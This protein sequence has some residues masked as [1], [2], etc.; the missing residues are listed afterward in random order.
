MADKQKTIKKSVT[1][2]GVGLH[3]GQNVE[4]TY[5]PAP[6][7]HG[8]KFKRVDIEESP[9]IEAD[10]DNVIDTSRGTTLE[11]NNIRISTVEHALAAVAGLSIDNIIIELNGS[12]I[13]ILDGSAKIFID[14][15]IEAGIE[16]QSSDREYFELKSNVSYVEED[17]GV[18]ILAIP[19][20]NFAVT[21]ML[22]YNSP[23]LGNQHAS[24]NNIEEFAEEI[25]SCRTFCFLHELEEL[26]SKN[27]IKGGDLSNAIVVVDRLIKDEELED[28]ANLFNNPDVTI[29][30]EGIVNDIQLRYQNEPARHKLL[31]VV[32]DLALIGKPIK[33]QIFATR[34]GHKANI[35]FAKKIKSIMSKETKEDIPQFDLSSKPVYDINQIMKILPHRAPFLFID[36]VMELSDNHVV[37]VKNLT[38][39]ETFF[40]GHFPGNPIFPGVLQIE[41]MAQTGGIFVLNTVPD[42]ENYLTYFMKIDKAKFKNLVYPGDVVIYRLELMSPIRR[43]ICHMK[44]TTYVGGKVTCEAEMMAVIVKVKGD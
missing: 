28:L 31:D 12:E 26:V 39:N 36:R 10:V 21:V 14:H 23:V 41:G 32:G 6:E 4:M 19:N 42:P 29:N 40:R 16:E 35:E 1:I 44:G 17:R 8:I 34:P 30:K 5:V 43:R 9:I 25:S 15:L 22:D 2:E 37:G 11:Q 27:L 33:G 24:L 3:T 18:E 7:N 38:I 20:E 13:P